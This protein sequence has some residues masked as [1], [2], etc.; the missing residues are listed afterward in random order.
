MSKPPIDLRAATEDDLTVVLRFMR[1]LRED[2]PIPNA[3]F[4][5]SEHALRELLRHPEFGRVYLICT[6]HQTE[7]N[8]TPAAKPK[9]AAAEAADGLRP[10]A[11]AGSIVGYLAQCYSYS[12]EFGGRDA[13]VDELLITRAH[14]GKGYGEAAL[15]AL[16][17]LCQKQGLK[18]LNLEVH[19]DNPAVSLYSRVRFVDRGYRLMTRY[20]P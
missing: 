5:K 4:E 15:E 12:L 7:R 1:E 8:A 9:D 16:I 17:A 13:F 6:A 18:A 10:D 14:R 20:L 19:G 3:T 2:D 11:Q